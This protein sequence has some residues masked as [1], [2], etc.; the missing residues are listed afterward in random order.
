LVPVH[1]PYLGRKSFSS[2]SFPRLH[3][4]LPQLLWIPGIV[5][6]AGVRDARVWGVNLVSCSLL[7]TLLSLIPA[8]T[9]LLVDL[10]YYRMGWMVG[11]IGGCDDVTSNRPDHFRDCRPCIPGVRRYLDRFDAERR[12]CGVVLC[13]LGFFP[14]LTVSD[15]KQ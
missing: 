5:W 6:L 12:V 15:S 13:D 2:Y 14:A 11:G 7:I 3:L 1:F 4:P 10:A 9:A 8:G